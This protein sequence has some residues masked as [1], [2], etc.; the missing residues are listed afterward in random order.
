M[1][2]VL[3]GLVMLA[4]IACAVIALFTGNVWWLTPITFVAIRTVRRSLWSRGRTLHDDIMEDPE[5]K[6]KLRALPEYEELLEK[7]KSTKSILPK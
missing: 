5:L 7:A 2:D 1:L 6:E 4:S 3:F